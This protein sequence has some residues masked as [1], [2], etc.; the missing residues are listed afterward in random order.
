MAAEK[1]WVVYKEHFSKLRNS[2]EKTKNKSYYSS[3]ILQTIIELKK[4]VRQFSGY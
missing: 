2:S 4:I 1:Q 3:I